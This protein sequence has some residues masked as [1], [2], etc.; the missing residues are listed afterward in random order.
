MFERFTDRARRVLLLAQ[1]EARAHRQSR[2]GTEHLLIALMVEG[3][4]IAAQ[5]LDSLG[6]TPGHVREQ[7]PD[8]VRPGVEAPTGDIAVS[9]GLAT[10]VDLSP[11]EAA[12]LGHNHVGPEHLLLSLSRRAEGV[13][14]HVLAEHSASAGVILDRIN[15]L[16]PRE[17]EES[18]PTASPSSI[19]RRLDQIEE[20]LAVMSKMLGEILQ[21]LPDKQ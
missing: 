7:L 8:Q 11:A 9:P 18:R 5:A 10:V 4:S 15:A 1:E 2:I 16:L 3:D 14:A 6:V 21:R 19:G 12:Q 20:T 13:T 17:L